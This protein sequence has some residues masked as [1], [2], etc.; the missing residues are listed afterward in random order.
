MQELKSRHRSAND[1][2]NQKVKKKTDELSLMHEW[3][4]AMSLEVKQTKRQLK[5]EQN[6]TKSVSV[7]SNKRLEAWRN[8]KAEVAELKD[9]LAECSENKDEPLELINHVRKRIKKE[10][11]LGRRGGSQRWPLH[12]IMLVCE[13]LCDGVPPARVRATIQT[14][15]AFFTGEEAEELPSMSTIRE[16]RSVIQT[17][18]DLLAAYL[19]AGWSG[20]LVPALHRR[21][22]TKTDRI[23]VFG[24]WFSNSFWF[25]VSYCIVV[26]LHGR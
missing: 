13:L 3:V 14:T 21:N 18:N 6:K 7:T 11:V 10:C 4:G 24:H 20:E 9:R 2:A 5:S 16:C 22:H 15:S 19:Q 12:V 17:L 8:L 23:P 26:H 25:S 1:V